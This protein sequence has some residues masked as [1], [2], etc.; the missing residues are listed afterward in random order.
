MKPLA[1]KETNAGF[2]EDRLIGATALLVQLA[3]G[4]IDVVL[5]QRL[6]FLL[7]HRSLLRLGWPVFGGQYVRTDDGPFLRELHG[8]IRSEV[9]GPDADT[10]WLRTFRIH[11]H[12]ISTQKPVESKSLSRKDKEQLD[13]LFQ[14]FQP[15]DYSQVIA[16]IEKECP[17]WTSDKGSIFGMKEVLVANG[18]QV[19][20]ALRLEAQVKFNT[21]LIKQ[22]AQA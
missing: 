21:A 17:E 13:L 6:L 15:L 4:E 22:R 9:P 19:E 14:E 1:K 18:C 7:E 8:Q 5:A 10:E 12:K 20:D 11:D 2:R 16:A 3:G